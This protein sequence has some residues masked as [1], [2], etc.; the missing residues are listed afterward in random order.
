M[1]AHWDEVEPQRFDIG[2]M[3]LVRIDLGRA[4]GSKGVGL[5][6]L[7]VDPGSQ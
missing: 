7:E 1:I 5:A 3:H 6:R 2:Q 4:A